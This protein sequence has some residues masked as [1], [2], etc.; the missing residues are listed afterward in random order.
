MGRKGQRRFRRN[1]LD[2]VPLI[3][4]LFASPQ[5]ALQVKELSGFGHD[6][7]I[8][9][10]MYRRFPFPG[11]LEP[12]W[13]AQGSIDFGKASAFSRTPPPP[14][15]LHIPPLS[16]TGRPDKLIM[17]SLR[18]GREEANHCMSVLSQHEVKATSQGGY[19]VRH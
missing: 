10:L 7:Y 18:R 11:T 9:V 19:G 8:K 1:K 15:K 2:R 4:K 16:Q 6:C 5:F 12:R 17:K 13:L 14:T 3:Q